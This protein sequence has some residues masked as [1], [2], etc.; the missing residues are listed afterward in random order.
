MSKA[1][2]TKNIATVLLGI[3]MIL[4][5]FAYSA[6]ASAASCGDG[7]NGTVACGNGNPEQVVNVWGTTNSGVPH[8]QPGQYAADGKSL[9][10][11]FF[12][13]YCVDITNTAYYKNLFR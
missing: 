4:S 8:I 3:G 5:V 9:C 13:N 1:L 12:T 7:T 6:P 10:P 2:M 11:A